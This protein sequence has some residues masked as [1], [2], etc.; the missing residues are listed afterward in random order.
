MAL[1]LY[2]KSFMP[3][4]KY[5][6]QHDACPNVDCIYPSMHGLSNYNV[7]PGD[8]TKLLEEMEKPGRFGR[9]THDLPPSFTLGLM[10]I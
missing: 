1:T 4:C 5:H 10:C 2:V 7:M 6:G 3:H 8:V 9:M